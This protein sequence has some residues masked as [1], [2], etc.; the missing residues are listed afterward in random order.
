MTDQRIKSAL[1]ANFGFDSLRPGQDEAI[2]PILEGR[3]ALIVMP[4]GAG[5]SLCFQ[6]PAV[7][8]E[9]VT[10]VISPLIALMQDQVDALRERDIAATFINS[11][12]DPTEQAARLDA[13]ARGEWDLCYVAPERLRSAAFRRALAQTTVGRLAID[14][15]HCI[16]QWGHDFRPEYRTIGEFADLIG[17][18][19]VVALTAT[20]TPQVQIDIDAQLGLRDPFNLVTG[21]N[22]PNL[23]LEAVYAPGEDAKQR[24]LRR[25][26]EEMPADVS[27]IVY[28]G[29]RRD[30]ES[31]S[32][33][34]NGP[35]GRSAV[36]YHA[37]LSSDDRTTVQNRWMSGEVPIIVATNAFGMGVDKA[38]VRFVV[39]H[40]LPG[41]VEAYYQEAGRAGRDD[42]QA[43]CLL[44]HGPAD[45]R[46][47]EYFIERGLPTI[48]NLRAFYTRL[49]EDAA[50]APDGMAEAHYGALDSAVGRPR[51]GVA[52]NGLRLLEEAGIIVYGGDR[53]GTTVWSVPV[54][55]GRVDMQGP[56]R[57]LEARRGQQRKLLSVITDYARA[58]D[59]RR[60]YLL[61]YFGDA[62]PPVAEQC[63]DRCDARQNGHGADDLSEA[64]SALE[65]EPL[66]VFEAISELNW[67]V[68][69]STIAKILVG[70]RAADIARYELHSNHG[71]L[72]HRSQRDVLS[73]VDELV[74]MGYLDLDVGKYPTLALSP[75]GKRALKERLAIPIE[76]LTIPG[77]SSWGGQSKRRSKKRSSTR[78]GAPTLDETRRLHD[79]GHDPESIA[80]ERGLTVETVYNHLAALVEAGSVTVDSIVTPPERERIEHAVREAGN[81]VSDPCARACAGVHPTARF[82]A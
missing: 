64:S 20:A 75:E 66:A 68:G 44:L 6:L 49:R 51:E 10:L 3:D 61:D 11:T 57:D 50:A 70:S 9:H 35:C 5:K 81:R 4:T 73:L 19:P 23:R 56:L 13:L 22:R 69:R 72:K 65:A 14:E 36:Y 59:C 74:G 38:D 55:A 8:D 34:I 25:F 16:S 32:E 79:N 41:S 24:A 30:A 53:G 40:A 43:E 31:I 52:R 77:S 47:H 21:F 78:P 46:L 80:A 58:R 48:N 2:P 71:D 12:L 29:K 26:L 37:G 63:C 42:K 60:Q 39:H 76:G 62:S 33:F 18:P 54:P 67:G 45:A 1:K 17:R 7:L 82:D 27:G 15:A 28:V